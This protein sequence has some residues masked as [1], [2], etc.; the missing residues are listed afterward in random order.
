MADVRQVQRGLALL[1]DWHVGASVNRRFSEAEVEQFRHQ[2]TIELAL[3]A[4]ALAGRLVL[5]TSWLRV[6]VQQ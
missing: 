5:P 3:S 4:V 6:D 1:D 2:A